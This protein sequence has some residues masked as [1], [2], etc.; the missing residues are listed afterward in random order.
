[1]YKRS[2]RHRNVGGE[3]LDPQKSPH[4][5]DSTIAPELPAIPGD[6]PGSAVA[7]LADGSLLRK[8]QSV[9]ENHN[10][11]TIAVTPSPANNI[12]TTEMTE[13]M[14]LIHLRQQSTLSPPR[15]EDQ[16]KPDVKNPIQM[17]LELGASFLGFPPKKDSNDIVPS[18]II[19][20]EWS[21]S[22]NE[23]VSSNTNDAS[24]TRTRRRPIPTTNIGSSSHQDQSLSSFHEAIHLRQSAPTMLSASPSSS[25][26]FNSNPSSQRHTT[27]HDSI[28]QD[29]Y[30]PEDGHLWRAKFCVLED[31]IL[32]FYRHADDGNSP[33]AAA[34]RKQSKSMMLGEY[35][36]DNKNIYSGSY[37]DRA[38]MNDSRV[39]STHHPSFTAGIVEPRQSTTLS[40]INSS[41]TFKSRRMISA[42]DLSKSPMVRPNLHPL[43]SGGVLS[44]G[45]EAS[46]WE[47]RVF[48]DC[49]GGVRTAEQQY[50]QNS[51]ELLAMD[52]DESDQNFVD[53]LVLKGQNQTEMKEWIFQFHRSLASFMRN[54]ID[55]VGST[56]SGEAFFESHNLSSMPHS[57]RHS[58]SSSLI[59]S[60]SIPQSSSEKHLQRLISTS[61]S[62]QHT[63]L[64]H[65]HGRISLKRRMDIKRTPSESPSISSTPDTGDMDYGH[66][67]FAFREPSPNNFRLSPDSS[68]PPLRVL[69]P[70]VVPSFI[71]PNNNG[72]LESMTPSGTAAPSSELTPRNLD[73]Q[74]ELSKLSDTHRPKPSSIG[75]KY[76]PPHLRKSKYVPPHLR[77]QQDQRSL[78]SNNAALIPPIVGTS[79]KNDEEKQEGSVVYSPHALAERS[80]FI[81]IKAPPEQ[82]EAPDV[83]D[84]LN[85]WTPG[86]VRGGCADPQ[87]VQG[88]ILD[89]EYIP[90]KASRLKKT[91][92]KAYG[93]YGGSY[94]D[95]AKETKSSLRWEIGAISE[96][97][98]RESN[99][100]AY[101]IANDLL[102]ALESSSYGTPPQTVWKEERTHHS[103]GLFGIFDGHC[104]NQGARFAVEQLGR[105]IHDELQFESFGDA[106]TNDEVSSLDPLKIESILREAIV[107]LDVA[108]CNLCQE[109]GREWESGATAL[110]AMLANE[111]LVIASL[112]DCRGFLCRF[113]DDVESY[114]SDESWEQLE[115]DVDNHGQ[116][117]AERSSESE[118]L[119]RCFWREVTTVHSPDKEQERI[120]NAH[121]WITTETEIPIGQL[122]RMDFHDED[123]I[124]IL[125]RCMRYPSGNASL[126]D[127]ERSTKEC[128][129]APQRIIHISRVCGEL[130]VS[131]AIGDRDFKADFNCASAQR[132]DSDD[133]EAK[134]IASNHDKRVWESPLFLLYPENHDRQFRGDL[135]TNSPDFD[136]IRLGENGV[137]NE[138]LLLACDGLWDVM[139]ADDAIRI[140]RDLLFHKKVTAKK[141]AARLAELAIHLGSS[142]N[143]TV[144][145]LRLFSRDDAD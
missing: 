81:P 121:G 29:F 104:G 18:A 86:F 67:P 58:L 10:N 73:S 133:F 96:C 3:F 66:H 145:L 52:D 88:S 30:D 140:V 1:L 142:D 12:S 43:T 5:I 110:V 87:L 46:I 55:N 59:E 82:K 80:Q 95:D 112:G 25:G 129:A 102:N 78:G 134:E 141:A 111:N 16:K 91:P 109:E 76:I 21:T 138:F 11:A 122:R 47:K 97:G 69:I 44:P 17:G 143:I 83:L 54:F 49:V 84:V 34:E 31:G 50:G 56:S 99:E 114:N 137:S 61:P 71:P 36:D 4:D 9:Y 103:V 77:R 94:S 19:D 107:K 57:G 62:L 105:F 24:K 65:G 108:F 135:I 2:N 126:A 123:V 85:P 8:R 63:T 7:G 127:S 75:G 124:G 128:K 115:I 45:I 48:M 60:G 20:P 26:F 72:N 116:Y 64:S 40:A 118:P 53:T 35:H 131:R 144:L 125:K 42:K 132:S 13:S 117:S 68:S 130:A 6:L 74:T 139:D 27:G 120:E 70:P 38:I 90:K 41:F 23:G 100:D 22:R 92:S 89:N 119:Q 113:V 106:D 14:E 79:F 15:L 33:E 136:R 37:K 98:V 28:P 93:S 39:S 51:F 32:Y 101:L